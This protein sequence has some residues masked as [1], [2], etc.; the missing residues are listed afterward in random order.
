M[1][2][3]T[4]GAWK[5]GVTLCGSR[6]LKRG[7]W[8]AATHENKGANDMFSIMIDTLKLNDSSRDIVSWR[9]RAITKA[10][11]TRVANNPPPRTCIS[12]S[13]IQDPSNRCEKMVAELKR[14][15]RENS[16]VAILIE[17]SGSRSTCLHTEKDFL[18]KAPEPIRM[19]G[20]SDGCIPSAI[21][22]A[23]KILLEK[24][25]AGKAKQDMSNDVSRASARNEKFRRNEGKSVA[26]DMASLKV[27]NNIAAELRLPLETRKY[28]QL[29]ELNRLN[30]N[31][32]TWIC[33]MTCSVYLVRLVE[34][35]V[36]DHTVLVVTSGN[37]CILYSEEQYELK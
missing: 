22:N 32:F 2:Y 31:P 6:I 14:W 24:N 30:I 25:T 16:G 23:T 9:Y 10:S 29:E 17:R 5:R 28:R 13:G 12:L 37:K 36:V 3:K 8:A 18:L 1:G 34:H 27:L 15:C 21:L 4:S 26:A 35:G 11:A 19:E 20:I 33:S 7:K